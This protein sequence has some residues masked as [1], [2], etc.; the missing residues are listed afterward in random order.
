MGERGTSTDTKMRIVKSLQAMMEQQPLEKIKVSALCKN[1][2]VSRTTFY[3]YFRDVFDVP[4]WLWD[5]FMSQSL[6]QMGIT[7][8]CY[9]AHVKNFHFLKDNQAFFELAFKSNHYNSVFLH[10]ARVVKEHIIATASKNAGRELNEQ[11]LRDIEF[12]NAGA[13]HMTKLWARGGMKEPPEVMANLFQS[14]TP[15]FLVDFLEVAMG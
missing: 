10:G 1:A 9:D 3:E 6:Y 8:S 2:G 15:Q 5:Y 12:R 14:F 13:A 7:M 4:T 11:E